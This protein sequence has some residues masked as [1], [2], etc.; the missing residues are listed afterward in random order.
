M[1]E[2]KYKRAFRI[3]IKA[4]SLSF[5]VNDAS[6]EILRYIVNEDDLELISVKKMLYHY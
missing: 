2:E 4:R 5:H 3:I 6:L 1:S